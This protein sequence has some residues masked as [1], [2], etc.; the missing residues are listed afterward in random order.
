MATIDRLCERGLSVVI[1]IDGA[2]CCVIGLGWAGLGWGGGGAFGRLK[3]FGF[4]GWRRWEGRLCR[5]EE[6]GWVISLC[7]LLGWREEM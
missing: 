6:G 2:F 7:W 1:C 3:V 5:R 4:R